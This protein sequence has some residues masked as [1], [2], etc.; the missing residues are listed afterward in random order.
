MAMA[1]L[2][3]R[4]FAHNGLL[5]KGSPFRTVPSAGREQGT[6]EG[7]QGFLWQVAQAPLASGFLGIGAP[8]LE[9]VEIAGDGH[10][11]EDRLGLLQHLAL[12]VAS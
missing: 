11:G 5:R 8:D 1:D 6:A 9:L 7:S 2:G 10:L 3:G 4:P 12:P